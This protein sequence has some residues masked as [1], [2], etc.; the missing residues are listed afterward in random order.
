ML[1]LTAAAL[2]GFQ[3]ATSPLAPDALLSRP[4][5]AMLV[6][7]ELLLALWLLVGGHA[8]LAWAVCV[9]LFASFAGYT[10]W[11]LV[12]GAGSCGCFGAVG[13]PPAAAL[14]LDLLVLAALACCRPAESAPTAL[15]RTAL[16]VG[17]LVLVGTPAAFAM[18]AYRPAVAEG[19]AV[20]DAAV[21]LLEP[22]SGIGQP[23]PL[24]GRVDVAADLG[25]GHWTVVL[26][27]HDCA[28][29]IEQIPKHERHADRLDT[30][31]SGARV[32]LI[33]V[34]PHVAAADDL[35]SGTS[36]AVLGRLA[37]GPRWFVRTPAVLT[38]HD[39][40]VVSAPAVGLAAAGPPAF[41]GEER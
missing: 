21:V 19:G 23:F 18:T 8:R 30:G 34:P 27:R 14:S 28:E 7:G 33:A 16:P 11:R 39:G 31:G 6:E 20:P 15:W 26:Y 36:A 10:L 29:C 3:L 35:P 2:K 4:W 1:L 12:A 5:A 9:G 17:L 37:D 32:A 38:L 40:T 25:T 13:V 24:T 41:A 22:D